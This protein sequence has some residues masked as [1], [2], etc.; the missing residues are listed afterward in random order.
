MRVYCTARFHREIQKLSKNSSYAGIVNDVCIHFKDKTTHEVHQ[1]LP[2][3]NT[4]GRFSLNKHRIQN[5]AGGRGKSS[6]YRCV[7]ICFPERDSIYLDT[8]YPKTGSEGKMTLAI[9]S[10][11]RL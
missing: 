1:I 11:R 4:P 6:S 3:K 10:T 2:I 5:L 8:I 9:K 7:L